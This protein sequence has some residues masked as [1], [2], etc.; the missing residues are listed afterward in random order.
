MN[1]EIPANWQPSIVV[2]EGSPYNGASI[3][4]DPVTHKIHKAPI[5]QSALNFIQRYSFLEDYNHLAETVQ[6]LGLFANSDYEAYIAGQLLSINTITNSVDQTNEI[7]KQQS[8]ALSNDHNANFYKELYEKAQRAYEDER[9]KWLNADTQPEIIKELIAVKNERAA[10]LKENNNLKNQVADLTNENNKYKDEI[11]NWEKYKTDVEAGRVGHYIEEYK[12]LKDKLNREH[13]DEVNTLNINHQKKVNELNNN[14]Y[15]LVKQVNELQL[16]VEKYKQ[17]SKMAMDKLIFETKLDEVEKASNMSRL[18]S[19][20][21]SFI[22]KVLGVYD[23]SV[24]MISEIHKTLKKAN[25]EV[26]K[27]SSIGIDIEKMFKDIDTPDYAARREE[28]EEM[29]KR[30]KETFA[31]DA[32]MYKKFLDSDR[33]LPTDLERTHKLP[34]LKKYGVD[35][36]EDEQPPK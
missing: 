13:R 36:D 18:R 7:I 20:L 2:N 11:K 25:T 4:T 34:D 32:K 12:Q 8:V 23:D 19:E 24:I 5:S 21:L 10:L 3:F 30:V 26:N 28:A 22:Y 14:I 33:E 1:I 9:N 35:D 29:E 15:E 27:L 6:K 16:K 31:K 17:D